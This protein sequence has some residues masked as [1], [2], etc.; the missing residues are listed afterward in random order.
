MILRPTR[1][2]V[3][4]GAVGVL[5]AGTATAGYALAIEP[6][7]RL[8]VREWSVAVPGWRGRPPLRALMVADLHAGA[9]HMT[10]A[11]VER[12]VAAANALEP[13]VMLV[14]GDLPAHHR[15]LTARVPME[16]VARALAGLRAPLGV[17][18]ILGNHDW[19]DDPRAER[20]RSRPPTIRRL[21]EAAG[22]PVLANGVARLAHGEGVWLAG[23]DS[24]W[25]FGAGYGVDDLEGTL[26]QVPDDAPV[27]LL[28]HE[29]DIFP[30]VPAR[31]SVTF[32]GH[33]HGGQVRVA[34]Y[35]PWV[36]SRFGNRFAYGVV[37]EAGRVLVVSGGLGCSIMPVRFGVPP[38]LT[39]V[40]LSG[41]EGL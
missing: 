17:H 35:S 37:R 19:W 38:E 36:P 28:A 32:S 2:G 41:G 26:A 12:I 4:A 10:L 30:R 24:Q 34:G 6:G 39:M 3:L 40:R 20:R 25:A 16:G 27:V 21:L 7:W 31:V 5:G 14:M 29:P 22:V 13:D 18:A 8:V 1:R 9:P 23:L 33:T 15:Y 11:R